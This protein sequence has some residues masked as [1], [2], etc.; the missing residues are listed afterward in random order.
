[1][2]GEGKGKLEFLTKLHVTDPQ[3]L[4]Q[5][6]VPM[7]TGSIHVDK[8]SRL[9]VSVLGPAIIISGHVMGYYTRFRPI[10][11]FLS[12]FAKKISLDSSNVCGLIIVWAVPP[13][14]GWLS[15]GEVTPIYQREKI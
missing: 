13:C 6:D 8:V 7:V 1:M 3:S 9:L 4:V 10:L 5:P 11:C 15:M 14:C 2:T 12:P